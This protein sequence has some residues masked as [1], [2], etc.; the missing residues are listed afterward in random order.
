[1]DAEMLV[2]VLPAL[3]HEGDEAAVGTRTA[4]QPQNRE[5]QQIRQWIALT[6]PPTGVGN[7]LQSREKI[8]KRNHGILLQ[9]ADHRFTSFHPAV[10]SFYAKIPHIDSFAVWLTI[11]P[12][13][14]NSPGGVTLGHRWRRRLPPLPSLATGQTT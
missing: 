8:G 6:L 13:E 2:Q 12:G 3:V 7:I 4:Q 10:D 14:P 11:A 5:Q 1:M 9:G